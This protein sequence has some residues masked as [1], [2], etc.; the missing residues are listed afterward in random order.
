MR[1]SDESHEKL[2]R[3]LIVLLSQIFAEGGTQKNLSNLC[4]VRANDGLDKRWQ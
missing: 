2:R 3:R 1:R 4:Y